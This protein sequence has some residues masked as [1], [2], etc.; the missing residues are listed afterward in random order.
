[1]TTCNFLSGAWSIA[2]PTPPRGRTLSPCTPEQAAACQARVD[3]HL[4]AGA[5]LLH[6]VVTLPEGRGILACAVGGAQ[7]QVRF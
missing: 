1:M 7:K 5:E 6:A 3:A 4:P 2:T